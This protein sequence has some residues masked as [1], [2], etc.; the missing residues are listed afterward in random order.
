MIRAI[1]VT[2]VWQ[3]DP[4]ANEVKDR[5]KE[6]F[7]R[8][9]FRRSKSLIERFVDWLAE[10]LGGQPTPDGFQQ[11]GWLNVVIWTVLIALAIGLV[12]F[13]IWLIVKRKPRAKRL[14]TS[15]E[16]VV[17]RDRSHSEWADEA[18]Q[19]EASGDWKGAIRCRYRELVAVLVQRRLVESVPGRTTGELRQD[20]SASH[21]AV[22]R[23]FSEATLLFELPWYGHLDTGPAENAAFKQLAERVLAAAPELVDAP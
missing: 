18:S 22:A 1:L 7:S 2:P 9:E 14:K 6:I 10:R 12:S 21:P 11:N 23:E 20:L 15:P 8:G 17:E 3:D 13:I 16:L 19:L 4:S 5:A